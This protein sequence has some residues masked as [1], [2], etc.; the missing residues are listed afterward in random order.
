MALRKISIGFQA[1]IIVGCLPFSMSETARAQSTSAIGK[2]IQFDVPDASGTNPTSIN[3]LGAI[4]GSFSDADGSTAGFLR[5]PSGAITTFNV[6][7]G[8][9]TAPTSINL[10]GAITGG[11]TD[12]NG[13]GGGF[14]R[15]SNGAITTFNAPGSVF[16]AP[17]TIG[18]NGE[19][20][21]Y[22]FDTNFVGHGFTRAANGKLTTFNVPG[23]GASTTIFP[24]GTFA[25]GASASGTLAGASYD[26]NGNSSGFLLARNGNFI[27]FVAPGTIAAF[28]PY[29]FGKSL[30]INSLGVV[31]GTYFQPIAG[32]PFGG[33]YQ[34]FI[35]AR[36][37]KITTFAA[38]S[39]T[40]CCVWSFPTGINIENTIIGFLN[41]AHDVNHGFIRSQ[42]GSI[43]TLDAPDAGT[44]FHEGTIPLGI[45]DLGEVMGE[46]IDSNDIAHGFI[47]TPKPW[48]SALT[49]GPRASSLATDSVAV[50]EPSTWTMMLVG[51]AGLGAVG[52]RAQR[53]WGIAV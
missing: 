38:A 41:D 2:Y 28:N 49:T 25:L 5:R 8:T 21:G 7:G 10:L 19:V 51:F 36:D 4:T 52:W 18:L 44:G 50:P 24:Q 26:A 14:V 11:F 43:T 27:S 6:P 46:V 29:S 53:K 22:Y 30:Y 17:Q 39:S 15:A 16:M 45:T 42:D 31:A 35:R 23:A 32:N 3:L 40:P 20:S 47:L 48:I 9:G 33:N 12:A 13:N 37:G 1:L 34:V